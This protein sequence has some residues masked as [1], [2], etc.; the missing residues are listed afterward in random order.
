ME[1]SSLILRR[2]SS[3]VYAASMAVPGLYD[4]YGVVVIFYP[5]LE[6]EPALLCADELLQYA[7]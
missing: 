7:V 2:P 6:V 5:M 4:V 3:A 1:E